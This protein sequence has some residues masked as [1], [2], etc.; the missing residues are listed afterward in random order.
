MKALITALALVTLMATPTFAR[1]AAP[2]SNQTDFVSS[3]RI[4]SSV[5]R[6]EPNSVTGEAIPFGS[7]IAVPEVTMNA[8]FLPV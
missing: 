8:G 5:S 7:G 4:K 1:K 6:D 2:A 3:R